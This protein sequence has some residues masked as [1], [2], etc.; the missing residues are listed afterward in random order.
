[1]E[2]AGRKNL[3]TK[4]DKKRGFMSY[5]EIKRIFSKIV[6]G[7]TYLHDIN[8]VHCDL[9]L[10]NIVVNKDKV[11]L[12]DFGFSRKEADKES[13][14][15]AGTPNYMSPELISRKKHWPKP[16]DVWSLGVILYYMI[17]K[18]F[19]FTGKK[20]TDL[21]LSVLQSEPD[22]E[23]VNSPSA[24][25]L[26]KNILKKEASERIHAGEILKSEFLTGIKRTK[27]LGHEIVKENNFVKDVDE[28]FE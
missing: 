1:M 11:K 15:I 23:L 2:Y 27:I 28:F 25:I 21:M 5:A 22:Y 9:K 7:V 8:I 12:V 4:I 13:D 14:M 18:R 17:T 16:A 3:K 20:E 19:P 10:E 24:K 26:L 6:E